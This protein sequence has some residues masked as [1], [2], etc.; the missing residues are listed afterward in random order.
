MKAAA[1]EPKARKTLVQLNG[2]VKLKDPAAFARH[3]VAELDK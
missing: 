1:K 3:Q 2:E